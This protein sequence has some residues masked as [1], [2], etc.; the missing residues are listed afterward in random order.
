MTGKL[1]STRLIAITEWFHQYVMITDAAVLR[2]S[3]LR[4]QTAR[5]T[6]HSTGVGPA[7]EDELYLTGQSRLVRS[8]A[9]PSSYRRRNEKDR[10]EKHPSIREGCTKDGA[11][12]NVKT[13][14]QVWNW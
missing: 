6:R 8:Q 4:S 14:T 13:T 10:Q 3:T 5:H 12:E 11:R 7:V 9:R 1:N 2:H